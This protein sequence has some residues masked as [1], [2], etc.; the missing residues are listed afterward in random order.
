PG[1][2][3]TP[4][5]HPPRRGSCVKRPRRRCRG[6]NSASPASRTAASRWPIVLSLCCGAEN[7]AE[8]VAEELVLLGRA[9]GDADGPRGAEASRRA[10]DH[11]FAEELLEERARVLAD[12]GEEEVRDRRRRLETV[13]THDPLELDEALRV[14]GAAPRELVRRVE[15]GEGCDLGERVDVES[16]PDL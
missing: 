2:G 7:A 1:R 11:T 9:N 14:D 3:P 6:H 4:P 15:A 5:P 10:D 8:S 16:P 13:L 12:F